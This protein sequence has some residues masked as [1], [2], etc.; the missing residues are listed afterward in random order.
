MQLDIDAARNEKAQAF[1]V[2]M[3]SHI[4]VARERGM[5]TD[6]ELAAYLNS[7]G[8]RTLTKVRWT[9]QTVSRL[10]LRLGIPTY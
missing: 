9:A 7:Q 10:R 1:D 6:R 4:L 2:A 8:L 5:A 3:R